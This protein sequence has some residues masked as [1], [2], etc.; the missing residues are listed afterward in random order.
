M[1]LARDDLFAQRALRLHGDE[2]EDA[3]E[4][5][6]LKGEG[7]HVLCAK[8]RKGLGMIPSPFR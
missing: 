8:K 1:K 2:R 3:V 7:A 4:F 5:E 6:S